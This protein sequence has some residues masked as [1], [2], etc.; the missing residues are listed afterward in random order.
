[1]QMPARLNPFPSYAVFDRSYNQKVTDISS[2]TQTGTKGNMVDGNLSTDFETSGI[3]N[4]TGVGFLIDYGKIYLNCQFSWKASFTKNNGAGSANYSV[5]HS[6]DGITWVIDDSG[7]VA[8]GNTAASESSIT[9]LAIRYVRFRVAFTG[10]DLTTRVYE[11]RLMG[12]GG[13]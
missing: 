4:A 2:T 8:T 1:M 7:N 9:A 3:S 10:L 6:D 11:S 12:S 5:E 13:L